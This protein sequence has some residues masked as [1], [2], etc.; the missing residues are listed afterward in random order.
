M[1]LKE[2]F[3]YIGKN[4]GAVRFKYFTLKYFFYANHFILATVSVHIV[5]AYCPYLEHRAKQKR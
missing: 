2:E 5:Q 3:E 1:A 4:Y